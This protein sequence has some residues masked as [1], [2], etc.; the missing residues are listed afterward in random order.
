MKSNIKNVFNY[1]L[2][3]ISLIPINLCIISSLIFILLRV[4][5]GDPTMLSVNSGVVVGFVTTVFIPGNAVETTLKL[6]TLPDPPL[7]PL[8]KANTLD[9]VAVLVGLPSSEVSDISNKSFNVGVIV[10]Y[11]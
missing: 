11:E 8:P 9:T 2:I 6:V 1:A 4:A 10:G 7:P 3:K 5:P